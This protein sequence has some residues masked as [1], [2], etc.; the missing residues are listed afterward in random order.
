LAEV[1]DD[2]RHDERVD[3]AAA[4]PLG[5][6]RRRRLEL[7]VL[8]LE[9]EAPD[10]GGEIGARPRR[11][12]GDEAQPVAVR[13]QPVHRVDRARDRLAGDVEDAVDVQQNGG[14]GA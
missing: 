8:E 12:V 4:Q 11:V 3:A 6:G 2:R 14:H 13:A 9:P 10:L 5:R 7:R 1:G